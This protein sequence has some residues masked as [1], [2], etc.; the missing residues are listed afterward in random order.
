MQNRD[1]R[2]FISRDDEKYGPY[3]L[4]ELN[5]YLADGSLH[6]DDLAWWE[7]LSD[8]VKM[9]SVP[10]IVMYC[11]SR[12]PVSPGISCGNCGSPMERGQVICMECGT[13]RQ[14]QRRPTVDEAQS[15]SRTQAGAFDS[16]KA[17]VMFE[18]ARQYS[19]CLFLSGVAWS[20]GDHFPE[21]AR[22]WGVSGLVFIPLHV[23]LGMGWVLGG[24]LVFQEG[25]G[26]QRHFVA[27]LIPALL[28]F[29]GTFGTD[30]LFELLFPPG[31]KYNT[32]VKMGSIVFPV[33][34]ALPFLV[35]PYISDAVLNYTIYC[36]R[37]LAGKKAERRN[38]GLVVVYCIMCIFASNLISYQVFDYTFFA[39]ETGGIPY[40][41]VRVVLFI[42]ATIN[43]QRKMKD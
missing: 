13:R 42:F 11:E 19:V 14:I 39:S 33:I 7:G 12:S 41:Y 6:P 15:D 10:G 31:G 32:I 26:K 30:P 5:V 37:K 24:Y 3:S 36:G 8:W 2:V 40:I 27:L 43:E 28:W 25:L 23:V 18:K 38:L 20:L 17:H 34:W 9:E 29:V 1:M 16:D 22:D 21:F 4:E 35:F